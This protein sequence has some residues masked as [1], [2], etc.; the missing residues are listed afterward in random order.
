M[1]Y[2]GVLFGTLEHKSTVVR[3]LESLFFVESNFIFLIPVKLSKQNN[4]L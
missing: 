2:L 4:I 1:C 3:M